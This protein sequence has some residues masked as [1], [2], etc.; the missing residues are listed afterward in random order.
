M[1]GIDNAYSNGGERNMSDISREQQ[2]RVS[3]YNQTGKMHS[4][5]KGASTKPNEVGHKRVAKHTGMSGGAIAGIVIGCLIAVGGLIGLIVYLLRKP[6]DDKNQDKNIAK[7]KSDIKNS[8]DEYNSLVGQAK[9]LGLKPVL[10]SADTLTLLKS[11]NLT[12]LKKGW[13]SLNDA[14][15]ANRKMLK[16]SGT[17]TCQYGPWSEKCSDHKTD[18]GTRPV[19]GVVGKGGGNVEYDGDLNKLCTATT[20]NCKSSCPSVPVTPCEPSAPVNGTIGNCGH[21][22]KPG[23][24]CTPTCNSGFTPSGKFSCSTDGD[25]T[26]VTCIPN[27]CAVTRPNSGVISPCPS[28]LPSGKTCLPTC[29]TGYIASGPTSCVNGKLTTTS[30]N[31][32]KGCTVTKPKYGVISPCPSTL[33]SGQHCQPTCNTGYIASIQ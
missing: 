9:E 30:C 21:T 22:L 31:L 1:D 5:G 2:S 23:E 4:V 32:P 14:I 15:D 29:D 8:M 20:R 33:P 25:L 27:S 10:L 26:E 24:S 12:A 11:N 3:R 7:I 28:T 18:C 17:Y 6:D 16:Q 13:D 19:V